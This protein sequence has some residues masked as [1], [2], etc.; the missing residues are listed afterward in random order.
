MNKAVSVLIFS[1]VALGGILFAG[2]PF[3]VK[4]SLGLNDSLFSQFASVFFVESSTPEILKQAAASVP[5]TRQR[6]RVLVVP[7]HDDEFWG[8]Q[9]KDMKE[10][11]MTLQLGMELEKF[12]STDSR[13]EVI[14]SRGELGYNPVLATY[15]KDNEGEILEYVRGKKQ[16]MNDLMLSGK[17]YKS[18]GVFH[19]KAPDLVAIR[20]YGINK[21]AN[22]NDID[23]VVHI[24]FNDYPRRKQDIPGEYSGFSV[25]VP[26][27]QYSNAR[28][29][30]EVALAVSKR[31]Q[32][33]YQESNMP[34]ESAG[35]VEDQ[36]LIAIGSFNS[37]DPASILIEYGYIYEPQFFNPEIR[38]KVIS[39]MATQTYFGIRDF[40][41]NSEGS[42][43]TKKYSTAFLPHTWKDNI[44]S[45]VR[46]NPSVL[47]LQ[48]AL[49]LEGLYPP[50]ERNPHEC[51]LAGIFGACTKKSV[52]LF[53]QKYGISGEKDM[54]GE[55][56]REKLNELYSK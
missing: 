32:T 29:S 13:L 43:L 11:R 19:N 17:V 10:A 15:F 20:L 34:K 25:Y 7:G 1:L 53:Q 21:W 26:E 56:T 49:T 52:A 31:L 12:L 51:P 41:D 46:H 35:V 50:G 37:L 16:I 2:G 14:T 55:K 28:A 5:F 42:S 27:R 44:S 8:T 24:H 47:S 39:D 45:G 6:I 3:L 30:K 9:Y 36:D 33:Y 48:A 23:L 38:S 18:E 40:L 4:S 22:E 54:L